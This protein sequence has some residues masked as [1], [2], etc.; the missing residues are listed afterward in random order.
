MKKLTLI[1]VLEFFTGLFGGIAFFGATMCLFLF[2]N[3][4]PLV[5][6]IFALLVFGVFSFFSIASK[7]LSILLKSQS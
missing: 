2:K 3:M 5:C 6:F 4:N 1:N 7:S